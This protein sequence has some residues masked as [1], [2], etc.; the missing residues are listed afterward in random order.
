[1]GTTGYSEANAT[2]LEALSETIV[3]VEAYEQ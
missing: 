1:M 2:F 3:D